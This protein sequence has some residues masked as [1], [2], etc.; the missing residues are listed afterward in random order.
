MRV[1]GPMLKI[2]TEL[3]SDAGRERYGLDLMRSTG[4]QSGTVYRILDRLT[5]AGLVT[6]RW[7]EAD[8]VAEGR[9]RR[10]LYRL[11]GIGA[12]EADRI[13]LEHGIAGAWA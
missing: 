4:L 5:E 3:R 6:A 2:L 13:L 7:E 8:P 10:R 9:P 11:T 1:T 12:S